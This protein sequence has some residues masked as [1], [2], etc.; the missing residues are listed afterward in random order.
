MPPSPHFE[1]TAGLA[2]VASRC[3]LH[4]LVR[5]THFA[6]HMAERDTFNVDGLKIVSSV[7]SYFEAIS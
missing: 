1:R 4:G 2:R 5:C 7:W 3:T 6:S